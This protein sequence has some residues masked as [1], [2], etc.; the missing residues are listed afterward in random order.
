MIYFCCIFNYLFCTYLHVLLLRSTSLVTFLF[1]HVKDQSF[2]HIFLHL[3]YTIAR[4]FLV[5]NTWCLWYVIFDMQMKQKISILFSLVHTG[6]IKSFMTIILFL[7]MRIS[8]HSKLIQRVMF[9]LGIYIKLIHLTNKT[10]K[11]SN[12]YIYLKRYYTVWRNCCSTC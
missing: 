3:P 5:R 11:R 7:C 9:F 4:N 8:F 6:K 12:K 2:R 10:L 1:V